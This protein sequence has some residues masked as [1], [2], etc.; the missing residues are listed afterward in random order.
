[1][2]KKATST[3]SDTPEDTSSGRDI[4][5]VR[6][7]GDSLVVTLTQA[8]LSAVEI[9]EGDR[10]MLEPSPPHRIILS[11]ERKASTSTKRLDLEIDILQK[12]HA[13]LE[14]EMEYAMAQYKHDMP[15]DHYVSDSSGMEVTMR[16]L[17]YKRDQVDADLAEKRLEL[18]D[19]QGN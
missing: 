6:K 12:K 13:A 4:V 17:Q 19:L 9:S 5:R 2:A 11:K 8:V 3:V 18:F 15:V 1:M 7:V 10:L 16:Q 14:S